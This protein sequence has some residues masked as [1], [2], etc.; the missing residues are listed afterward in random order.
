MEDGSKLIIHFPG[1]RTRRVCFASLTKN[2]RLQLYKQVP[3][4]PR[5]YATNVCGKMVVKMCAEWSRMK[6]KNMR[7]NLERNCSDD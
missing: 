3:A 4:Q 7:W 2:G 5:T 6:V 1:D